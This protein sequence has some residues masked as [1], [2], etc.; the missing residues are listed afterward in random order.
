[1]E[2]TEHKAERLA[3]DILYGAGEI[4]EFLGVTEMQVYHLAR[5]K[6]IPVGKLGK[7]LVASKR[8]LKRAIGSLTS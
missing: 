8:A 3:D 4:A 6:R 5:K 7:T 2:N 1:M